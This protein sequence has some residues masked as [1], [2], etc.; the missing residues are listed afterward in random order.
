M[1]RY[2]FIGDGGPTPKIQRMSLSGKN[3]R[4]LVSQGILNPISIAVDLDTSMIF[5]VDEARH[6]LETANYDGGERRII[7]RAMGSVLL[8]VFVY[9]VGNLQL[10]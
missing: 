2:L 10:R 4:N 8:D 7:R 3:R 9:R 5:W 1:Y 6:T